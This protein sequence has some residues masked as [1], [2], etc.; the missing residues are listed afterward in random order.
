MANSYSQIYIQYVWAVKGRENI[1][2][3]E[4]NDEIQKYIT[5]IVTNNQSKMYAINNMPDHVHM[6]VSPHNTLSIAKLIQ[7]VKASSSRFIN[8]K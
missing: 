4:Y 6:F 3:P 1:I 8:E 7:E 2:K 5:G